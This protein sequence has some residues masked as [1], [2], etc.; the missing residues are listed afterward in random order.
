VIGPSGRVRLGVFAATAILLLGS[1]LFIAQMTAAA[2]VTVPYA[3][4]PV[5]DVDLDGDPA[6]GDWT[7]ASPTAVPLENGEPGG[8]GTVTLY[9][10][11]D[12]T[13]VYFRIDGQIDVPWTS[14]T[15]TH[16]WL[17][18]QFS[19]LGTVHH[20]SGAW[21]GL[22]FGLWDGNDYSPTA[23]YPPA[24]VDTSGFDRPPLPDGSQDDF[25]ALRYSGSAAPYAFTAEWRRALDTGDGNDLP[26]VADG[27]TPLNFFITTDSDGDGS[28]GG[29]LSHNVITNSNRMLFQQT[30][31]G[32]SIPP[33]ALVC[34]S[35]GDPVA[36]G[37]IGPQ[38]YH[39]TYVDPAT[40]IAVYMTCTPGPPLT[41][42]LAL[43]APW[44]G[45]VSVLV[46]A[47][48]ADASA[49]N[50]VRMMHGESPGTAV[51][52]DAYSNESVP[53]LRDT[54]A[55]GSDDVGAIVHGH[56]GP[57]HQFEFSLP[58]QTGDPLDCTLNAA[59]PYSLMVRYNATASDFSAGPQAASSA[60]IFYVD[61]RAVPGKEPT[62][63]ELVQVAAV[64]ASEG[65]AFLAVLR[66]GTAYPIADAPLQV[67]VKTAFGFLDLG[68]VVTN[69]DGA[70]AFNYTP[71]DKGKFLIGVAYLGGTEHRASVEWKV[72]EI[73]SSVPPDAPPSTLRPVEAIVAMA[74]VGV[75]STYAY[76]FFVVFQTLR[77][78]SG[79]FR[80][81][82]RPAPK[83]P[84]EE[85][86]RG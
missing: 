10:K 9:S 7:G 62:S 38:E 68:P 37:Q 3:A 13:Y 47:A 59:G 71:R 42:H 6:T 53:F 33:G 4:N 34:G 55:G 54:A 82:L 64:N 76:A 24:P 40:R 79:R 75:W 73:Q 58:L 2:A 11:H 30:G 50:E 56:Q 36:D 72:V 12:G 46:Q 29:A 28:E 32:P 80:L 85:V 84:I 15:G 77:G 63:V 8:Y 86:E 27:G 52:L 51:G 48:D 70:A 39:A 60:A 61:T 5:A 45:W 35:E 81:R 21:D 49:Y 57:I 23:S 19:D 41:M 74:L 14:P 69:E 44:G 17:G 25:G 1:V 78:E 67:T 66:N 16:F 31:G 83:P 20:S 22:F 43:A 26:F 18:I 65:S